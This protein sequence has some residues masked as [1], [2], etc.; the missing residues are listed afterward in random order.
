[1]NSSLVWGV[2]RCLCIAITDF[3]TSQS[4]IF[5]EFLRLRQA[6]A[7]RS[8]SAVFPFRGRSWIN[9]TCLQNSKL[10]TSSYTGINLNKIL[11]LTVVSLKSVA[12]FRYRDNRCLFSDILSQYN[13]S[14]DTWFF[15]RLYIL[16]CTSLMTVYLTANE[17]ILVPDVQ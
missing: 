1:M 8:C 17:F 6:D 3:S 13:C 2:N 10:Y 16:F 7:S 5:A 4:S 9:V 12:V 14:F 15:P 11:I